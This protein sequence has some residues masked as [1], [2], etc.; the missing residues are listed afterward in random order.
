[1]E[2]Q[3]KEP[4]VL[5]ECISREPFIVTKYK[6]LGEGRFIAEN[7]ETLDKLQQNI[8]DVG[9]AEGRTQAISEF[10]EK[11]IK[12]FLIKVYGQVLDY[13]EAKKYIEKT[14]QEIR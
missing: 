4:K 10:K 6:E 14:A 7:K 3:T 12:D 1:M 8:F 13:E 9:K 5:V 11:L 2:K